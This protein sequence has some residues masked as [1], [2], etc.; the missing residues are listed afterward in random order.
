MKDIKP[1]GFGNQT[2]NIFHRIC[3]FQYLLSGLH[4]LLLGKKVV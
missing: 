4:A 3:D 2:P 1:A